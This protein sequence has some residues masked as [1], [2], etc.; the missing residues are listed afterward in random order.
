MFIIPSMYIRPYGIYFHKEN[1][2]EGAEITDN[3]HFA[4]MIQQIEAVGSKQY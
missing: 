4:L 1:L 2:K 3:C